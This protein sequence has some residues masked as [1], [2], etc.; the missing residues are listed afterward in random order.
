MQRLIIADTP[1][2]YVSLGDS[3]SIDAY[4]GGPG[5]GA[6]ALLLKNRND[7]FPD[8]AGRDLVS[9]LPGARLIPL[10]MDGGTAATVRYAQLPRLK[11]MS[12]RSSLV[13]LTIGGNDLL[14]AYGN[15]EAARAARRALWEHGHAILNDLRA[16]LMTPGAPLVIGTIYDPS[17]G[18]GD[19]DRLGLLPWPSA[20]DWIARFNETLVALAGEHGALVADIHAYFKGH[21]LQAGDPTNHDAAPPNRE[22]WLC[23]TIEPNAWGAHAIRSLWWNTLAASGFFAP[24]EPK[25][26]PAS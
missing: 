18:T 9:V 22:L 24:I 2:Y 15:D 6:P 23:G 13:T 14:Q 12:V 10:A 26:T 11:E 17:D 25:A 1:K 3:V 19:T 21:A 4:A 20:L 7:N 5:R 8:W 16:T